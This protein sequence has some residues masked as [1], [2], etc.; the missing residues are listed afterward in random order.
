M[1][2]SITLGVLFSIFMLSCSTGINRS[3]EPGII[4]LVLQGNA[5]DTTIVILD[6]TYTVDS[7]SVFNFHIFEGRI[8]V[9]SF[10]SDLTPTIKDYQDE[11]RKYNILEQENRIYKKFTIYETYAPP[12]GYNKI[13]FGLNVKAV[14]IGDFITPVML[15]P[16][17]S[18]L[19]DIEYNFIIK[20][21][22]TT[23]ILFQIDPLKSI[24]RY[25]DSFLFYRE[26]RVVNV[27][28]Y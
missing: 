28:Y 21:N 2:K 4:K 10:Y 22:Q 9:D 16:D 17:E 15:P 20:E 11:G 27:R 18:L 25:R 12:G 14:R 1:A 3:K 8:Y 23:E 24:I 7:S 19:L 6:K 26:L 13:Q 5:A